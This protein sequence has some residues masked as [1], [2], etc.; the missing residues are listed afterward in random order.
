MLDIQINTSKINEIQLG[1]VFRRFQHQT[2]SNVWPNI[3]FPREDAQH[4]DH[5]QQNQL[6]VNTLGDHHKSTQ[7]D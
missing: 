4:G 2:V 7:P 6:H 3:D 5:I 1:L